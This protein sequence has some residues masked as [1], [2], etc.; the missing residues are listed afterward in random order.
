VKIAKGEKERI[1]FLHQKLRE[2]LQMYTKQKT[3]LLFLSQ[4]ERKYAKRTIQLIVKKAAQKARIIKH[5]TPHTLRHCFATHLLENGADIRYIQHLLGHK[6]L[7]TTQI[8]T[9][10]ANTDI[11]KLAHLL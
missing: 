8:Y 11:K 7:Q 10:I 1:V 9:H 3:G 4:H 5:V 6:N 2:L